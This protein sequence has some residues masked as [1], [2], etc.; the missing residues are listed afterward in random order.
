[1]H[2]QFDG[3]SR[4]ASAGVLARRRLEIQHVRCRRAARAAFVAGAAGL[5]FLCIS[6]LKPAGVAIPVFFAAIS[7]LSA[8]A[9]AALF[10][11]I[12]KLQLRDGDQ[13]SDD[14]DGG[15]G[16]GPDQ[17]PE[18]PGG[19]DLEF[20]WDC[21]ERDFRAYCDRVPALT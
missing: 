16:R 13:D 1:M 3:E 8:A 17:P 9:S 12:A 5:L 10:A 7:L 15:P 11:R 4:E 19:G 14:D 6:G 21:F 2:P 18:S 20:D